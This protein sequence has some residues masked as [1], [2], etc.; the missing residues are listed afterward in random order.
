MVTLSKADQAM[1]SLIASGYTSGS[2]TDRE[3]NYLTSIE[4]FGKSYAD[5]AVKQGFTKFPPL[6]S[7]APPGYAA[8][9]MADNPFAYYRLNDAPSTTLLDSSG[10]NR[11]LTNRDGTG[12]T[13][14]GPGATGLLTT[15]SST[16]YDAAGSRK[17]TYSDPP[18]LDVATLVVECLIKLTTVGTNKGIVA[19]FS[20][21]GDSS[22]LI[23][24]DLA[25]KITARFY[26][27][28]G[29]AID[30][31]WSVTP[32][33]AT[34]YHLVATWDGSIGN[35]YINNV[36]VATLPLVGTLRTSTADLTVGGYNG[37]AFT[38]NGI[39][40]EV[41]LYTS[42]TPARIA[43]HYAAI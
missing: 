43:S 20:T 35:L 8:Q 1:V 27:H 16:A 3:L 22:F 31:T 40:D 33:V 26:N 2:L 39:I 23:W 15:D 18:W 24:I 34:K 21:A 25:G 14:L 36:V 4:S 7:Y 19:K 13:T 11:H 41:A 32:S 38:M 29:V 12:L 17:G 10:N 42:L 37:A 28:L 30:L 9:V 5:K 6:E